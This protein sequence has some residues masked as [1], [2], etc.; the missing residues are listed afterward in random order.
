MPRRR[1]RTPGPS[2]P[3]P[4]TAAWFR[5]RRTPGRLGQVGV[6]R[7]IL[8]QSLQIGVIAAVLQPS[9]WVGAAAATTGALTTA[10]ALGRWRGRWWTELVALRLD[11]RRRLGRPAGITDDPRLAALRHLVPDLVVEDVAGTDTRLGMGS[12]GAGW[13]AVLEVEP[14]AVQAPVPLAALARLATEAEQAGVVIQVVW[15]SVPVTTEWAEPAGP[16]VEPDPERTG[17]QRTV[18]VAVRLDANA[19]ADSAVDNPDGDRHLDVPAVLRE[20]TRRVGR[21]LRR[22]GLVSRVLDAP[23]LLD[24]LARSCDL[25]DPDGAVAT[26]GEAVDRETWRGWRSDRLVHRTYWLATWPDPERGTGLLGALGDLPA[27]AV[28]VALILE[29]RPEGEPTDLRCLV[30]LATPPARRQAASEHAERLARRYGAR[31]FPLDGE[32]APGVYATAPSG[33][34]AR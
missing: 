28:S 30:R 8:A 25:V 6:A 14:S 26:A 16:S 32:H 12:D 11:L 19:V 34:G 5:R 33:G 10:A 27:A 9:A 29:P 2:T 21:V 22:R 7:L 17:R 20:L 24:A 13:F 3:A 18:W 4:D 15:H 23:G 1:A 31:L